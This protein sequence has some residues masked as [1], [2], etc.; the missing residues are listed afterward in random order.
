MRY[1]QLATR[2]SFPTD[3]DSLFSDMVDAWGFGTNSVPP[4]DVT[5]NEK[6]YKM[7]IELPGYSDEDVQVTV[8]QH[9]LR[10]KSEKCEKRDDRKYLVR[11]RSCS[12]F[13]RAFTLPDDVDEKAISGT[14][15]NGMLIIDMPKTEQAA[16]KKIEI[17]IQ[18]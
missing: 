9:V 14:Y 18:K 12:S 1:N 5:E 17:A 13:E 8:D 4:V 15:R 11:E 6:L 2:R 16:P 3:F 10:I 7:E